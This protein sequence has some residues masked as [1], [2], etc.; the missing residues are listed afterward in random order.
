M[1]HVFTVAGNT[2]RELF[3][4]RLLYNL[5][6]FALL[7]IGS[8][9]VLSKLTLGE[10]QRIV[11]DIGL[12]SINLFGIAI[13]IF[14]GIAVVS[15]ELDR[16]TVYIVLTKPVSRASLVLGKYLGLCLML[17]MNLTIMTAS[18]LAVLW[19]MEISMSWALVQAVV[20]IYLE[21]VVVAALAILFSAVTTTTL[22]AMC[23]L[24]L[25]V[26]GHCLGTLRMAGERVGGLAETIATGLAY[27][28]P[29]LELFNL[30][31]VVISHQ[32]LATFEWSLLAG[33][34]G[35]YAAGLLGLAVTVFQ[36]KDL[37]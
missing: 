1:S 28:L 9:V 2:V 24:A 27:V 29:D 22:A 31:G 11:L 12:A 5:V 25:Y 20:S 23:T 4:D 18:L 8:S 13:A 32:A 17:L 35:A 7:L 30:K 3:R 6:A 33:Y 10:A 37:L 19:T 21:L 14:I 34:A 16:R 15:R 36:R 26:I